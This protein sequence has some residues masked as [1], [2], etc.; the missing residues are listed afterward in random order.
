MVM[1]W[2]FLLG[3][4]WARWTQKFLQPL[5]FHNSVIIYSPS[6]SSQVSMICSHFSSPPV[7]RF[8]PVG[9]QW[10]DGMLM[11]RSYLLVSSSVVQQW[12]FIDLLHIQVQTVPI[13]HFL[14]TS[15]WVE[16]WL[17]DEIVVL[18]PALL[19]STRLPRE[20]GLSSLQKMDA[21]PFPL[22]GLL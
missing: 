21:A 13:L 12:V 3:Q 9:S 4:G 19:T 17:C 1:L 14:S 6:S 10:C 11:E 8:Q 5:P 15:P 7:F 2:V 16:P 18:T 22:L 20:K